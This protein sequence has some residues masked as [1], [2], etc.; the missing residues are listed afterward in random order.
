MSSRRS[1]ARTE[2][3]PEQSSL[4]PSDPPP[5]PPPLEDP[6]R[7]GGNDHRDDELQ[8]ND[9]PESA[10]GR[11]SGDVNQE[12]VTGAVLEALANPEVVRRLLAVVSPEGPPGAASSSRTTSRSDGKLSVIVVSAFKYS[13]LRARAICISLLFKFFS[14]L[15]EH[16]RWEICRMQQSW[17]LWPIWA[18][19]LPLEA[20]IPSLLFLARLP[21]RVGET[22]A[23]SHPLEPL[24]PLPPRV[25]QETTPLLP[26]HWQVFLSGMVSRSSLTSWSPRS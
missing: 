26:A 12:A 25:V 9:G 1:R 6:E 11:S 14:W 7:D 22:Q 18:C 8:R 3:D 4:P 16:P 17:P 21:L 13:L 10:T 23:R 2:G 15:Q 5:P 24:S 20:R 19:H